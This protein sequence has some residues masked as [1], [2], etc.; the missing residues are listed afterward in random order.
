MKKKLFG[1]FAVT[2][3]LAFCGAFSAKSNTISPIYAEG[4]ESSELI[5]SEDEPET[6][7]SEEE[8]EVPAE[9]ESTIA[10]KVLEFKDTFLIPL[11]SGVSLSTIL[12]M[13]VSAAFAFKNGRV[14]KVLKEANSQFERFANDKLQQAEQLINIANEQLEKAEEISNRMI[15]K[16]EEINGRVENLILATQSLVSNFESLATNT[17]KML[18]IKECVV[19]LIEIQAELAKINPKAISSGIVEQLAFLEEQAKNL[20]KGD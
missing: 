3:A 4:E 2:V 8:V 17:S 1:L 16:A 6:A 20:L 19:L 9:S 7:D 12:G 13:A 10:K 15:E 14:V 18:A 11:L 5:S